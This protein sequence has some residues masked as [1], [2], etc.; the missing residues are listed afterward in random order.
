MKKEYN[1]LVRDNIP[2]IIKNEGK[3][4]DFIVVD[5]DTKLSLLLEKLI[6]ES[7]ELKESKTAEE[8]ADVQEVLDSI[9]EE[10]KFEKTDI[11]KIQI[12]KKEKRGSFSKGIVLKT[13]ED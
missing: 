12:D 8:I 4:C 2:E 3:K 5:N 1:K 13:V 10:L 11:L 6:E 7:N 9:I